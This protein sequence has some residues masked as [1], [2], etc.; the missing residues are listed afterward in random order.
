M[1]LRNIGNLQRTTDSHLRKQLSS[2]LSAV[3]ISDLADNTQ[4]GSDYDWRN[5]GKKLHF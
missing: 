5:G 3:I 2:L 4:D 1:F